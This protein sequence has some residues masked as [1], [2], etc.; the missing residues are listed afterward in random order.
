[1]VDTLESSGAT[2]ASERQSFPCPSPQRESSICKPPVLEVV[3]RP[4]STFEWIQLGKKVTEN[5]LFYVQDMLLGKEKSVESLAELSKFVAVSAL[6]W[7]EE[8]LIQGRGQCSRFLLSLR[9]L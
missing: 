9:H 3:K 4:P 7:L 5:L 8:T 1:M 2:Q 6:W